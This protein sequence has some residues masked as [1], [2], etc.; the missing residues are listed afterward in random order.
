M[1]DIRDAPA[2]SEPPA[3]RVAMPNG[4]IAS[5]VFGTA[6]K[7]PRQAATMAGKVQP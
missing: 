6:L 5:V 1:P 3:A 4:V 7:S 2:P